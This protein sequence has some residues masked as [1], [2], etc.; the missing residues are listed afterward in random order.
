MTWQRMPEHF[1]S[2]SI[3][4]CV[5]TCWPLVKHRQRGM[6]GASDLPWN[7]HFRR[8]LR[9]CYAATAAV[10]RLGR[11]KGREIL[12]WLLGIPFMVLSMLVSA[13]IASTSA[14]LGGRLRVPH[15]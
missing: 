15:P 1:W 8:A 12:L 2:H 4:G 6:T 3:A 5:L 13:F 9:P 11:S 7:R 10:D 14:A